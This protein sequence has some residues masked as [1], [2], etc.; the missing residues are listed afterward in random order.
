MLCCFPLG[1]WAMQEIR[2]LVALYLHLVFLHRTLMFF[3]TFDPDNLFSQTSASDGWPVL[4]IWADPVKE[5]SRKA[6]ASAREKARLPVQI[7]PWRVTLSG[8][9][10]AG[11]VGWR[12]EF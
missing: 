6:K 8:S 3:T 7:T 5:E 12:L 2:E 9:L 10:Y 4:A 11:T 1:A